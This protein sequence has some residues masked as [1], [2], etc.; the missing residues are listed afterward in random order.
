MIK[1]ISIK[2][3]APA[4]LAIMIDN[5]GFNLVYPMMT[6]IF[7]SNLVLPYSTPD[8]MRHFYLGLGY[9]LYPLGMFFGASFLGDLSDLWGRK[10]VLFV[11]ILGLLISFLFMGLGVT[12]GSLTA[13]L[14]GRLLS[15]LMAGSQPIAQAAIVDQSTQENKA[16][17]MSFITLALSVGLTLGPLIGS[18]ASNINLST[19][20]YVAGL[21]C[22]ANLVWIALSFSE[23]YKPAKEG[24]IDYLRPF[25]L[26]K[27]VY[28][29]K[30]ILYLSTAFFFMQ[31]GFGIYLPFCSVYLQKHFGY[32]IF[33]L[34][35]FTG[36][37]GAIFTFTLI[38]LTRLLFK[39]FLVKNLVAV[40]LFITAFGEIAAAFASIEWIFWLLA[41]PIAAGDILGYTTMLTCFSDEVQETKQGFVM[42]VA[43]SV[44]AVAWTVSG[45]FTNLL[46]SIGVEGVI[47]I[48]GLF[49]LVSALMMAWYATKQ[50]RRTP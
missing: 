33:G 10:K 9:I 17:N 18:F 15:G 11:S 42:G 16:L 31:I 35:I 36:W 8:S 2:K 30:G 19:P 28:Q 43:V 22:L 23:T 24:N 39:R 3:I 26:F 21:L 12:L 34:G 25:K 44:M 14:F 47:F 32:H 27:E 41:I 37:I 45:F 7:A 20:F 4:L 29:D 38:F 5:M 40:F 48:G 1:D 50:P 46:S 49:M 6:A 13:L